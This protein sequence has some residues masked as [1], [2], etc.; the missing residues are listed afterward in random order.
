MD[1]DQY[2]NRILSIEPIYEPE[3]YFAVP[4]YDF[5]ERFQSLQRHWEMSKD[6]QSRHLSNLRD[7]EFDSGEEEDHHYEMISSDS[8]HFPEYL[9]LSTIS[10]A[11]SLFENFL[12]ELCDYISS[13]KGLELRLDERRMP[14][15]EKYLLW[16]AKG[17]GFELS[18]P[19]EL[20]KR[21]DAGR[22]M[23]NRFV[24]RISRDIPEEIQKVIQNMI[25]DTSRSDIGVTNEFVDLVLEDVSELVKKIEM[26][27]WK[28]EKS[29]P[30]TDKDEI[31]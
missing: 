21:I 16:L 24:H 30:L 5:A 12:G 18:I 23:R 13:E 8:E 19:K 22:E 20:R 2:W 14:Y 7:V 26:S 4:F 10:I 31:K 29:H 17:C 25:S 6:S 28:F 15:A 27:Y 1:S 9:R 11:F 3:P